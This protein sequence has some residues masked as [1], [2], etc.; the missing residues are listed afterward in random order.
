[1]GAGDVLVVSSRYEGFCNVVAEATCSGLPLISFDCSYGPSEMIIPETN[2]LLVANGDV[3]GMAA[4]MTRM[5]RDKDLRDRLGKS[6][7]ITAAR[8][9]PAPPTR[10]ASMGW[11]VVSG[12]CHGIY[13]SLG[14][15]EQRQAGWSEATPETEG[16]LGHPDSAPEYASA[17]EILPCSTSQ[18]TASFGGAT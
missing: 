13:S 18:S 11:Q 5:A 14:T 7:H 8:L 1:M 6:A 9:S 3:A 2:G 10:A 15:L 4:A 17:F 16:H 12:V